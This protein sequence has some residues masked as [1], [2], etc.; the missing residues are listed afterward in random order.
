MRGGARTTGPAPCATGH[1]RVD[2]PAVST[3]TR[4][5]TP[6]VAALLL[7]VAVAAPAFAHAE[8]KTSDPEDAAVLATPPTVITLTFTEGLDQAKSSFVLDGPAG[9]VGTGKAVEQGGTV[10]TLAGLT[11]APG[12]YT[13]KWTSASTDGHLDRGTLSF[14]VLEP[15]S[16]PA[17]TP[18]SNASAASGVAPSAATS[19]AP[20]A[21]AGGGDAGTTSSSGTDV[22]LPII[23]GLAIVAGLGAFI[24]RRSRRA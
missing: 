22:L 2:S 8:I 18:P 6:V 20:A 16:A 3:S 21:S 19:A 13:I 23:L 24:L 1:A 5:I 9:A 15:A 11:L 14:T 7:V 17:T 4:S 12:A 10:M